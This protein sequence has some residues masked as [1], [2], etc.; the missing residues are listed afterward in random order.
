MKK[1]LLTLVLALACCT[2]RAAIFQNP[3]TTNANAGFTL[4]AV[5]NLNA[6]G[7]LA[8]SAGTNRLTVAG[9]QL[10]LDGEAISQTAAA[11]INNFF[12]T[13][14]FFISGKGNTLIITNNVLMPWTTLAFSG[15]SNVTAVLTNSVFA[16][17]LTN[18]AFFTAPTSLPG[19]THQQGV[20]IHLKQDATGGRTIMLTNS[21]WLFSGSS[22]AA[23]ASPV[24]NTNANG[25]TILTFSTS[26]FSATL[27]YGVPTA[28]TP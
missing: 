10:L 15:A 13:N 24:I 17:T 5:T 27:L 21:A 25:V 19:T 12:A 6:P 3:F 2:G 14:Q 11:A 4:T 26:P 22:A 8:L 20:Q 1:L 9:G 28:F 23:N 7:W 18:N 16:L